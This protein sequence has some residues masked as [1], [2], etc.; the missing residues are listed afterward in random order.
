MG[1]SSPGS[2]E[3]EFFHLRLQGTAIY[4]VKLDLEIGVFKCPESEKTD[5]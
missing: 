2:S 3:S 1:R 5:G 4:S